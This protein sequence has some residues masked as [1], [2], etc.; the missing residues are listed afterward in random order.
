MAPKM[1][2]NPERC[3]ERGSAEDPTCFD[4]HSQLATGS[5]NMIPGYF[6][7]TEA[8]A[9]HGPD[10][11]KSHQRGRI[12]IAGGIT[13]NPEARASLHS[14]H[15]LSSSFVPLLY[16]GKSRRATSAWQVGPGFLMRPR[17]FCGCDVMSQIPAVAHSDIN[18]LVFKPN[19]PSHQLCSH[20]AFP[21]AP[22]A[23]QEQGSDS[24]HIGVPFPS[25]TWPNPLGRE[26]QKFL[27]SRAI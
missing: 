11:E 5:S 20:D 3:S 1:R 26:L 14:V 22:I 25:N 16:L 27:K 10:L 2:L 23:S 19:P 18:P 8:T 15:S 6:L 17:I 21:R 12:R 7:T 13:G 9:G 4:P 24:G